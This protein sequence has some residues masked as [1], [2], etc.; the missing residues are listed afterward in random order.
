MKI[1]AFYHKSPFIKTNG[2]NPSSQL[3]NGKLSK[4]SELRGTRGRGGGRGDGKLAY[5]K[6]ICK[7]TQV[8]FLFS[9]SANRRVNLVNLYF[10]QNADLKTK[11]VTKGRDVWERK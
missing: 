8:P 10:P 2:Q 11:I 1:N 7:W 6:L 3:N 4:V 9:P 5:V